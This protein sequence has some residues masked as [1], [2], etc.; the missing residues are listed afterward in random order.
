MRE[1]RATPSSHAALASDLSQQPGSDTMTRMDSTGRRTFP[2]SSFWLALACLL[3]VAA[4]LHAQVPDSADGP[5]QPSTDVAR[6]HLIGND[7]I[8]KMHSAGLGDDVLVQTIQVQPGHYDTK[9]DDLIALKT[10][11]LSD[12]VIAAMQAHNAGLTVHMDAAGGALALPSGVDDIGLYYKDKDGSWQP[13]KTERVIFRSG[14]AAKNILTH[15][16]ISKDS[17]GHVD[18]PKS[19]LVLNTGVQILIYAPA[20]TAAE[21]Y[22]FL[23]FR[24]HTDYREFRVETGGVFHSETGGE[25]DEVE[26]HTT[27]M[28]ARLFTFTV[29]VD[30]IKGEYGILPPAS[31]NA[32]GIAGTGKIFTFSIIE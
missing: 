15:G 18:G 3:A 11:G 14:G 12:H 2:L 27:K 23:R 5:L 8:L 32:R 26:F 13:L 17:N 9:P 19:P 31:S 20:G 16:I 10:A 28:A 21:E 22:E 24:Q 25:R 7:T 4:P 29:P 1:S 6:V 30:I